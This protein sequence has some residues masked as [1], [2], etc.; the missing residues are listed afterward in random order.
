MT[1]QTHSE[2]S[3]GCAQTHALAQTFSKKG[4]TKEDAEGIVRFDWIAYSML[5]H[6]RTHLASILPE[7]AES[8][9]VR[10]IRDIHPQNFSGPREAF[11]CFGTKVSQLGSSGVNCHCATMKS[12]LLTHGASEWAAKQLIVWMPALSLRRIVETLPKHFL[13]ASTR[14]I[15]RR[16][17]DFDVPMKA[18][19]RRFDL[20]ESI[21]YDDDR[22]MEKLPSAAEAICAQVLCLHSD[23]N[24][25]KEMHME[26]V[27]VRSGRKSFRSSIRHLG[28]EAL[29]NAYVSFARHDVS[30]PGIVVSAFKV[31]RYLT[32]I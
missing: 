15:L 9:E 2:H 8:D 16:C 30:V 24:P 25:L 27:A 5:I 13:D 11:V 28:P 29:Q 1:S 4:M 23:A 31:D 10:A 21:P 14:R 18:G 26:C 17:E 7:Y 3:L 32:A 19:F 6:G 20:R 12:Q 22:Y